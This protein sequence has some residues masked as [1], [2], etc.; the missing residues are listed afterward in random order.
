MK[1]K[2]T[3]IFLFSLLSLAFA[4]LQAQEAGQAQADTLNPHT[5]VARERTLP[6]VT[7]KI[8][9]Q[10]RSYGDSI[11]L[12]WVAEDYVSYFYLA[13]FGVNV[14][15]LPKD[16][17]AG[18]QVDTLAYALKPKT[19][20]QFKAKYAPDDS[21]AYVAM[22]VLYNDD[23]ENAHK[24]KGRMGNTMDVSGDQDINYGFS[25]LTAEWRKDLAEDLAVR[26]T[27]KTAQPGAVYDYIVQPT[28]W[29]DSL[30][31]FEPG[32]AEDVT[33][34]PY[35]PERF[36]VRII[37]SLGAPYTT[38]IGW[39]D[40]EH[41]SFEVERRQTSTLTGEPVNGPWERVTRKPYVSMVQ[42]AEDEDYCLVVDS[43]PQLGMWEYRIL[44]YD[45]FADL[46]ELG[47]HTVFVPDVMPPLPPTLKTIV[48]ERPDDNDPMAKVY[49]HVI[50]EKEELE[51]DL[52][53][54]RIYYQPM[55]W[56][57][58]SWRLMTPDLLPP[59]DTL[60]R[61]DMTGLRTGMMCIA[62]YD[63]SGNE[64]RSFVQQVKLTDYK[65]P[66]I[67]EN[68]RAVVRE[69]DLENDTMALNHKW[70]YI[71]L[72]WQPLAEDDD[73]DYFDIAFAND[74]THNFLI[75]NQGGIRQSAYTDSVA[76]NANQRYIYYKVR[77]VDYS[78][79]ISEWSHWI[80]VERPH[81]TPPTVP[82]LGKSRHTDETGM[83]MEWIVGADADMKR[84]VLY[85]RLGE[86]GK[87]DIVAKYDADS[88]KAKDN[89]IIVHDNP[90]YSQTGRYYYFM[91]SI[92]ASPFVS[93]SLAVS[94]RH[95]GPRVL[96]V[97]IEL[98]GSYDDG[99]H[100]TW[101]VRDENLPGGEWHFCIYRKG[102]ED[103]GF[104]YYMSAAQDD[105]SYR[106]HTLEKGE[107]AEYYIELQYEDGRHSQ[108]SNT[109]K[110]ERPK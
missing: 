39:W 7:T 9:L 27:D 28:V 69:I 77:A 2:R 64:S 24:D 107:T 34:K 51:K 60:C 20:E 40:S 22:S 76:L 71:D 80:Q 26:F 101:F 108:S 13:T 55:Q 99:T 1:M 68:L 58:E 11:V 23:K 88:V 62:A 81:I 5:T 100:L 61:L 79:N 78:T 48:I 33:T 73:I 104:K 91:K 37:D 53:G 14:L 4:P 65:A 95:Q 16:P 41:S 19:L 59:T 57:N 35:N 47:E 56:E 38:Q 3:T 85:R 46:N 102:P 30:L 63:H 72:Y 109:V 103:K 52:A 97:P 75:R 106:E 93:R 90:P 15:R 110:V 25:M 92:N 18:I 70:A 36:D 44:G 83:Y 84:H 50:W 6:L 86:Q 32:V 89:T 8:Q 29:N 43:V 31:I 66:G 17:Q 94:W 12:R 42:Q 87:W 96:D 10:T 105:R 45:A 54:Y 21:L 74:T 82:H 49:A 98:S 67:P